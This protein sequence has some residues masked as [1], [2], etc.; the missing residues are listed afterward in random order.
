[1]ISNKSGNAHTPL[2]RAV[3]RAALYARVSTE[4]QR[5]RQTIDGQVDALRNAAPHWDMA[6][7]GEYLDD[8]VSGTTPMEKRSAGS[9]LL[10]D[11]RDGKF[12]VVI[13]YKLDRLARSLRNFLNIVDTFEEMGIGLRSMTETFDTSHPMGRF[14]IQMIA[15]VAEL[16]RGMII[17]R[18]SIGRERIAKQGRWTG[19]TVPYGY[20][21]AAA[22][23]LVADEVAR[24][25][26]P[27]SEADIVRRIFDELVGGGTAVSIA[28]NLNAECIP[29]WSKYHKKGTDQAVYVRKEVPRWLGT[30]I[31][32]IVRSET[33]KGVHVW[34]GKEDVSIERE[35]PAI[36]A[37]DLWER[38]QPILTANRNLSRRQDD[39]TYLLRGLIRCGDC[40][41][42]YHG[43]RAAPRESWHRYYYRCGTQSGNRRIQVGKCDAKRVHAEWL[44]E[45]VWADIRSFIENPGDVIEKLGERIQL[46]LEK[47]P[48]ADDREKQLLKL[49]AAK[50]I[51][52]DRVLD[53]YRRG[54]IEIEALEDHVARSRQEVEPLEEELSDLV[55]QQEKVGTSI[56]QL[57]GTQTLLECLRENVGHITDNQ[58]KRPIVEELVQ[59]IVVTT[60]GKR[61]RKSATIN[62]TY[63]FDPDSALEHATSVHWR[64]P[65]RACSRRQRNDSPSPQ[66]PSTGC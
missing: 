51:E 56:S 33:Y 59:D 21:L 46:E 13:F 66:G 7:V 35:V 24:N 39:R 61:R 55:H 16:E 14:A 4:D 32:R 28:S 62:V 40:G 30:T 38:A 11:A 10:E 26:S 43:S 2:E 18:T 60:V 45:A 19:G 8:G 6:I 22:G 53:A 17:E 9:R 27:F 31:I 1:M 58:S 15:S 37:V 63:R 52:K 20:V 36:V 34:N 50:K 3:T 41:F 54:L 5:E 44:E 57:A 29:F 42:A 49:I 12:D 47:T 48:A 25:G 64:T 65:P 23:F